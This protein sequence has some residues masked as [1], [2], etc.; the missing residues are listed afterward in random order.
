MQAPW[1][2]GQP[3]MSQ[4]DIVHQ[5]VIMRIF[6]YRDSEGFTLEAERGYAW[7]HAKFD[8]MK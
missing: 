6:T 5:C 2:P 1:E 7:M 8:Q 4:Q 3:I